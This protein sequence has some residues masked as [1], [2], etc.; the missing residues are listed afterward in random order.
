MNKDTDSVVLFS[1]ALGLQEPWFIE[2]VEL[3]DFPE[4]S[5]NRENALKV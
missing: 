1:L 5:T 4:T 2:D 3:V